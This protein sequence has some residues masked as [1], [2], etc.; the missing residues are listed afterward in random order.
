MLYNVEESAVGG[1]WWRWWWSEETGIQK[2]LP[3]TQ[4]PVVS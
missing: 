2:L 3:A 4:T 1:G